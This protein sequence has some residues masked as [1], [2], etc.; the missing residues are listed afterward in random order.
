MPDKDQS[1]DGPEHLPAEFPAALAA[2]RPS[3]A[4]AATV[5]YR[6][7]SYLDVPGGRVA[8]VRKGTGPP[9]LL[10]H[11]IPLSSFTW[12]HNI[13]HL[14]R[15]ATTIAMDLR[16]FGLSAKPADADYSLPGH[17][18]V[19]EDV[20]DAL[21]L[22]EVTVVAS[23][24]GS[25]VALTL[26]HLA[27]KRVARMV[28]I[29]P[30]C[31]PGGRH[32]AA[33]LARIGLLSALA[34]PVLRSS[35]LGRRAL[36][37]RLRHSYALPEQATDDVLDVY[38]LPLLADPGCAR[39]YLATL[40][41]LNEDELAARVPEISPEVLLL[42]GEKDRVLPVSDADRF[43]R[44]APAAH[45]EVLRHVGHLPQEETP[46][47]VNRFITSFIGRPTG[48]RTPAAANLSPEEPR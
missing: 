26:A 41:S 14:A 19:I 37:S 15:H 31:Y 38:Q 8:V 11:G 13:D 36:R 35:I 44:E 12:R 48:A 33:K 20:L 28:L 39:A 3:A 30:V 23:S 25:A 47:L 32:S 1:A 17:A 4:G 16:G 5:F 34:G 24:F 42:W 2:M 21:G 45:L 10:L 43:I 40:R 6:D 27:P 9:I 29:N 18:Q 22:D 46:E 7:V